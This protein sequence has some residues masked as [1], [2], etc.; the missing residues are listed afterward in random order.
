MHEGKYNIAT[1]KQQFDKNGKP[2]YVY[3]YED[4]N[5]LAH[6][7]II[8]ESEYNNLSEDEKQKCKLYFDYDQ[9]P[10]QGMLQANL[11]FM[12]AVLT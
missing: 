1:L 4:E 2:L 9:L 5:G 10:F 11:K 3:F 7:N 8:L 6:K 12:K